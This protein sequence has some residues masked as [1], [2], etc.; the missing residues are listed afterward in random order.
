MVTRMKTTKYIVI[1]FIFFIILLISPIAFSADMEELKEMSE[2][3]GEIIEG[4][5]E[6]TQELKTKLKP[7]DKR[8]S[9]IQ[10]KAIM[11]MEHAE[12]EIDNL[13]SGNTNN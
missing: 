5:S 3:M 8:P 9:D 4:V 7:N 1:T 12:D 13:S 11:S 6:K 2:D 10:E